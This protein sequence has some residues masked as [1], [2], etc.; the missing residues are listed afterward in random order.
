MSAGKVVATCTLCMQINS[1]GGV[2]WT[3][4]YADSFETL[5][6][7]WSWSEEMHVVWM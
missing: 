2:A 6:V 5:E 4:F 1:V 7:F 3:R